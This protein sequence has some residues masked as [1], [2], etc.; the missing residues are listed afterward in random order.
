MRNRV[1]CG[2]ALR[3]AALCLLAGLG[4]AAL[5]QAPQY[6]CASEPGYRDFDFWRGQWRVHDGKDKVY[7]HNEITSV[8][9][10]CALRERWESSSG[11]SG[12]SLNYY[13]PQQRQWRQLWVDSSGNI[14]DIQG[15]L[16]GR[17]ML[18][19]GTIRYPTDP[20]PRA[21]RGRWSPL[22][23]GDVRQF[24]EQRDAEGQWQTWFEGFYSR[25]GS[26]PGG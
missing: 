22:D 13:D 25:V 6:D 20:Q 24:F 2:G 14:I 5:G 8:E 18:L 10:G 19:T 1:R 21:F 7:G 23:N 16:E 11:G 15:A 3:C 26:T 4:P 12:Q 17:D 9:G